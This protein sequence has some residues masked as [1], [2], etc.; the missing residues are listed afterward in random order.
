M[1][2]SLLLKF[3][4]RDTTAGVTRRT[5]KVVAESLGLSET[6]VV[7]HALAALAKDVL[8]AYEMDDGPLSKKDIAW[9]QSAANEKL[10]KGELVSFKSLV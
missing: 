2:E 9:V 5:L 6:M 1:S 7:H 8:P 10:P 3:K 4:S